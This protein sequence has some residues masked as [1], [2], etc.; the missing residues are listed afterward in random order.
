MRNPVELPTRVNRDYLAIDGAR[1]IA[2]GTIYAGGGLQPVGGGRRTPTRLEFCRGNACEREGGA[3]SKEVRRQKLEARVQVRF[4]AA[5][6]ENFREGSAR[7]FIHS[8]FNAV[9]AGLEMDH[10]ERGGV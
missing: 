1:D 7:D 3:R 8:K 5:R 9:R 4:C 10:S 2:P 6:G